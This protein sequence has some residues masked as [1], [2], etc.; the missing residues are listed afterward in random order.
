MNEAARYGHTEIAKYLVECGADVNSRSR[1]HDGA[2][3]LWWALAHAGE[4]HPV[5][6]VLRSHGAIAIEADF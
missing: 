5:V 6:E 3:V 1:H 4:D 2:S